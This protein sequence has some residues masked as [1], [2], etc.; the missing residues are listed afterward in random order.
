MKMLD[1]TPV[2]NG[3]Q[4]KDKNQTLW[5]ICLLLTVMTEHRSSDQ[6]T[7]KCSVSTYDDRCLHTVK[8]LY[9]GNNVNHN[10]LQTSQSGCSASVTFQ[11]S[12]Y[13]QSSNSDLLKCEVTDENE[14]QQQFPFRLQPS[15][16]KPGDNTTNQRPKTNKDKDKT[17]PRPEPTT[18][19]TTPTTERSMKRGTITT[20]SA[21]NDDSANLSDQKAW[22]WIIVALAVAAALLIIVVAVIR[23]KR[24]KGKKTQTDQNIVSFTAV[25]SNFSL[26]VSSA[27]IEPMFDQMR[28]DLVCFCLFQ[29]RSLNPAVTAG[30]SQDTA[31]PEGDVSYASV[32]F[33]K[34]SDSEGRVQGQDDDAVTYTT[35]KASSSS[36][37]ASHVLYATVNKPNK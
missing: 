8:W 18:K 10:D 11:S 15:G 16:E 9:A 22:W 26:V 4:D 24:T 6:V 20:A 7:L 35:L 36:A 34:N 37:A 25:E 32:S 29:G 30:T 31:D 21:I 23:W 19:P 2:N 14:V 28:V 17:K 27:V 1:V 12:H 3:N 33:T 5:F 13:I